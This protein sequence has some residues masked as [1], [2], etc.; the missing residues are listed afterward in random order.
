[1]RK[2]LLYTACMLLLPLLRGCEAAAAHPSDESSSAQ[3][4]FNLQP[5]GQDDKVIA[6]NAP[7]WA[8]IVKRLVGL[9]TEG[10]ESEEARLL[11]GEMVAQLKADWLQLEQVRAQTRGADL[12]RL[13]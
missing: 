10:S 12:N 9:G 8:A 11:R 6:G 4:Q 1:M 7:R 3:D 5:S 2:A 13:V